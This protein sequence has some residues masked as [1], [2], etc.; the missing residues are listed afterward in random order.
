MANIIITEE[1]LKQLM[2]EASIGDDIANLRFGNVA[3]GLKG[4]WRGEGYD[5]FSYL[6]TLKNILRKLD[7]IDKPNESIMNDLEKIKSSLSSSKMSQSKKNN[8]IN[9][10]DT[11]KSHFLQYRAIIDFLTKKLETNLD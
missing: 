8:I 3:K 6:N 7:K 1:Q 5:Y 9:A 4:V 11:A 10:I 2:D